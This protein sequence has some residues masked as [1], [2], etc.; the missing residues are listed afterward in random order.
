MSS[1]SIEL[2]PVVAASSSAS[3]R[4]SS[5]AI[6]ASAWLAFWLI[7]LPVEELVFVG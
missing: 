7:E 5:L 3:G 4:D 2:M 1:L 6:S